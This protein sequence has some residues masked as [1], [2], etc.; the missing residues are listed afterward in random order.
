MTSSWRHPPKLGPTFLKKVDL[1][2][3]YMRIWVRLEDIPSVAFLV[4]KATPEEDQL[5]G[6]HLS[7]TM[8][9]VESAAFFYNTIETVKDCILDSLSTR[10]NTPPHHLEDLT[11]TKPPQTSVEDTEATLKAKRNW[12]YLTWDRAVARAC[13]DRS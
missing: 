11:D 10:H 3:A 8:G 1:S 4:P 6:F 7:I 2:D 9:Y 12:E 5:V 13:R